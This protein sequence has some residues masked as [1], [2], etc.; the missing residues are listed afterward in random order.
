MAPARRRSGKSSRGGGMLAVLGCLVVLGGT[1]TLG[2]VVGRHWDRVPWLGRVVTPAKAA[3]EPEREGAAR[4]PPEGRRGERMAQAVEPMPPLTFYQELTKPLA[5]PPPAPKPV[6][7]IRTETESPA[8]EKPAVA[9]KPPET[10]E[11]PAGAGRYTV[12]VG[13]YKARPPA[14]AL[15]ASL[16]AAG[17]DVYV[18]DPDAS[19]T[20]RVRVGTFATRDAARAAATRIAGERQLQTYVTTR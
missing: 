13:A 20:Y 15:R 8:A 6:K 3:T 12:Q 1:F 5:A 2:V 14:E 16:A 18:T 4:R 9:V 10:P 19:G 7:T 11:E 17:E